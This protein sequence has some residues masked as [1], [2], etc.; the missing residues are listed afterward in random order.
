MDI[1]ER[2]WSK[3]D[4]SGNC[5]MFTGDRIKQGYGRIFFRGKKWL[6]HRVSW[7]LHNGEIPEGLSCC[8]KCDNP[9]CVRPDHLFLA[10]H[11]Q[12]MQDRDNKKRG[13]LP[14]L[15]GERHGMSKLTAGDVLTIRGLLAEGCKAQS[16]SQFFGI[17]ESTISQIKNRR[18]WAHI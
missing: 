13:A 12:N 14:R 16:I 10:S 4:K 9:G 8:H 5:W 11:Q 2:F 18:R 15:A 3:V 1:A 17:A 7:V 6:A